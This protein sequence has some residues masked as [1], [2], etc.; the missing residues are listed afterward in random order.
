MKLISPKLI[1]GSILSLFIY[2]CDVTREIEDFKNQNPDT[3]TPVSDDPIDNLGIPSGFDFSTQKEVAIN[4]ND[5]E[6]YIKYDVFAYSD[7]K[8]FVRVETYIDEEGQTQ[9]DSVYNSGILDKLIFSGVVKNGKIA[10]TITVPKHFKKLYIRRKNNLRYTS[11]VVDISNGQ[12]NY[13][14]SNATGKTFEKHNNNNDSDIFYCVNGSGELFQVDPLTGAYTLLCNMPMGSYTCAIDQENKVLYSIGRSRPNPLMKYS[15]ENNTWETITDLRMGG[16]RLDFNEDD[17]LLYFSNW[18]QVFTINPTNGAIVDTIY[19]DGV[20]LGGDLVFADDGTMYM[21]SFTGVYRTELDGNGEYQLNYISSSIPF[22]LTS[23]EFD[24]NGQ[25]WLADAWFGNS[26]LMTMDLQSGSWQYA[27]GV[28]A[29]NGTNFNRKIND[30]AIL[31]AVEEVVEIPDADGDGVADY[32][33]EYPNDPE[34]AFNLYTPS[35]NGWGT[36]AFE[37]LWPFTGDYDFND[38]ALRYRFKAYLNAQNNIVQLDFIYKVKANGAGLVNGF[39]LEIEA[40][41]PG[42]IE[43]VTGLDLKH[44]F[45]NLNANGTE[46]GQSNAVFVMFDDARSMLGSEVTV[47]ID[48]TQPVNPNSLEPAPFNP[49]IIVGK[50]RAKEVH[51]PFKNPTALGDN[52]PD[53]QGANRD[54]DGNYVTESGLP[55]GINVADDFKVPN[56]RIKIIDA[57]NF[58]SD[59]A[60]SGGSSN[61]DWYEDNPGNINEDKVADE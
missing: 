56:E 16:P 28:S 13:Y 45:V 55:W 54:L 25:L 17:G 10:Q 18:D 34:R 47:S 5:S 9:T 53:L 19:M 15:I 27:Y 50:E 52:L 24:S 6:D 60:A 51:L 1:I 58:F 7:E 33:D 14:G 40:L 3:D 36:L 37:D 42:Q 22:N 43:S 31:N 35:E 49:F 12:V 44:G 48:F 20:L 26:D 32:D 11:E 29:N 46:M 57:Y 38:V 21:C 39:G 30:L 23:M 8:Q 59:W 4:I 41:T 2:S 61:D